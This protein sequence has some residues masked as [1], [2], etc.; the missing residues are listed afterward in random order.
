MKNWVENTIQ[1]LRKN[2]NFT[3]KVKDEY[4]PD[5]LDDTLIKNLGPLADMAR[6]SKEHSTFTQDVRIKEDLDRIND[7]IK[8]II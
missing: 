8:K 1:G 5:D 2:D 3:D 6:P 4:M 7:I